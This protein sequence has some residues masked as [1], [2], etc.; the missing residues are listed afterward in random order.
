[1]RTESEATPGVTG[2]RAQVVT[3][4]VGKRLDTDEASLAHLPLT[5]CCTQSVAE[6]LG[7]PVPD[8]TQSQEDC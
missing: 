3:R 4:A 1:M 6:G 7:A 5:S 2:D 8:G